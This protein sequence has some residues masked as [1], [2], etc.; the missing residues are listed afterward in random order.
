MMI[1]LSFGQQRLWFVDQ[2]DSLGGLYTIPLI[3][4][5]TGSLDPVSLANA[6][7]DVVAR[8]E[9]LRTIFPSPNGNPVQQ[10]LPPNEAVVEL[11]V[12][13]VTEVDLTGAVAEAKAQPFDLATEIPIRAELFALAATEH[14]LAVTIHHIAADGWSMGLL[15]RDLFTAYNARTNGHPPAFPDL[16][17]QY[18]DY[19]LWQRELLGSDDDPHSRLNQQLAYWRRALAH[20]PEEL[21]LPTDRPRPRVASHHGAT[22]EVTIPADVHQQLHALARAHE[23]TVFMTLQAALAVLLARLG[24][25]EDIPI[26]APIAGRTDE[27]FDDLIGFFVNTLVLR[28]DLSGNPTYSQTLARV[29]ETTIDAYDHQDL[30]FER[31]VE[32]LA[33]TRSMAR[34]PLFQVALTLNNTPA[35]ALHLPGLESTALP[36]GSMPA[37]FDLEFELAE[38]RNQN[39]PSGIHGTLTY[40]TDLFD[41][42]TAQALTQRLIFTLRT[43]TTHPDTPL[44]RLEM[45][46]EVERRRVLGE[47]NDTA[48]EVP[49]VTLPGLFEE[50]VGRIPGSTAVVFGERCVSYGE[51]NGRANRLARL[52]VARGVGAEDRV[53][54]VMGRGAELVVALLGVLKA[55]AA[56]VPIDPAYPAERIGFMLA[57]AQPAVVL[58]TRE[59]TPAVPE[60]FAGPLL[61]LDDP[62]TAAFLARQDSA[63]LADTERVRPLLPEHP[64]YVIFTSGSTGRPKGVVIPHAA[65]ANFLTDMSRRFPLGTEDCWAAVTTIAFD[66]AALELYLPLISGARLELVPRQTVIDIPALAELLHR[67][68]TTIMQATPS[69]WHALTEHLTQSTMELPRLRIL[70]GGE[71]LPEPLATTLGSLAD[72]TNLYGPTET[73]IWSTTAPI[74]P[75]RTPTIGRPIANT[76]TYVLDAGLQPV[77]TG[78][79]GELYIAG[80]GLARGYLNQPGLT[81][82]RFVACPFASGERMYRTGDVVRWNNRGELVFLGRADDQV[83]I[84]GFRIELGE[85]EAALLTYEDI[86]QAAVIVREDVLGD[87]RLA[88]YVVPVHGASGNRKPPATDG[89]PAVDGSSA[90]GGS[91]DSHGLS[92]QSVRRFIAARLPHFMVPSAVVALDE[93][94]LTVNGK[95]DRKALPVPDYLA[96]SCGVGGRGPRTAREEVLCAA[97]VEVLGVPAVGI[98]DN[99][100]ELGGHSLLAVTLVARLREQGVAVS[101]R[102]MFDTPTVAALAEAG[103][104]DVVVVPPNLIP[105]GVEVITPEML[106]LVD[107]TAAEIELIASLVPGGAAN[108]ADIYPLA[109]LQEGIFFHHLMGTGGAGGDVYARP[110]VLGFDTRERVD[111]FVEALRRVVERHDVLRTGVQW[112][113]LSQPV[114]VVWRSA[115]LPVREIVLDPE[116]GDPVRQLLDAGDTAIDLAQAPLMRVT[117]APNPDRPGSGTGRCP[118]FGAGAG[119]GADGAVESAGAEW[120]L[121]LC[122]HH[123]VQDHTAVEVMLG[124]V[125]AFLTGGGEGL[126]VPVPFRDFVAQARLGAPPWEHVRYFADLLGDVEEPSAPFGVLDVLGDGSGTAEAQLVVDGEL[127]ARVRG[128]ARE[129]GVSAATVM[130]AAWAR[131]VAA[132]SGCDDVVFGTVLFGRMNAGTGAERALGLFINTLPVRL[133]TTEHNVATAL[134]VMQTQLAALLVREHAPLA[135]AQHAS[136]LTP[137]TPL[138]TTIL[139]YRHNPQDRETTLEGI[140]FLHSEG[141]TNYPLTASIDD[142]GTGFALTVEAVAPIDPHAVCAMFHT[143]IN[144]FVTAL[145]SEPHTLLSRVGVLEEAE[146][147]LLLVGWNDTGRDVPD[148]TLPELFEV[149]VCRT[150]DSTAVAFEGRCLSYAE[151][152][153]RANQLARLLTGQGVGAEDRVAVMMERSVDLV[154]AL[155]AVLKTGAA[156]LPID[157]AYPGERITYILADAKPAIVLTTREAAPAVPEESDIPLLVPDDPPTA[158]VLEGEDT[159]DMTDAERV[160]PLLPE[161]PAYV[162]YT[163][164]STGRPKGV[165]VAQRGVVNRLAW[166]QS[167]Y[168]LELGDR[169]LQKT[170]FGFDVSVWEFF[171]PL[172]EGATLVVARPGGHQDPAYL[173]QLIQREHITLLHFVPS[174]LQ[175]FLR[176]PAAANCTGLRAVLCSGE[177]LPADLCDRFH[178]VLDVP[179]HNLY[180]PTEASIDVTAWPCTPGTAGPS[181]PIGRPV[182]NTRVFV[183]DAALQPVPVGVPAE[184]YLAG[185][186]LARGYLNQPALTAERFI[187]CPFGTGERMYRTGDIVRWN[188]DGTLVYLGRT[189]DQVKIRGFR[190]ELGEIEAALLSHDTI[191]QAAVTVR[192]DSPGGK[193]LVAYVVPSGDSGLYE[194]SVVLGTLRRSLATRLPEYMVPSAVVVLEELPLTVNG[195][196]DRKALPA[197]DYGGSSERGP[198]TPREE[199]LCAAFAE[200]LGLPRVGIDDNFF[201]LGGH[202]L[203]SVRLASRVQAALG[204]ELTLRTLFEAPTVARLAE[205]LDSDSRDGSSMGLW[206]VLLPLRAQGSGRPLFC[207]HPGEGMSWLYA[208]LM[209][210]LGAGVPIY[211]LQA[212]GLARPEAL[213]RS[214]EEMAADYLHEIRTVQPHGPYRLLGWSFGGLVAHTIATRLQAQGEQVDLLAILDAYPPTSAEGTAVDNAEDLERK[215]LAGLLEDLGYD[216]VKVGGGQLSRPTVAQFLQRQDVGLALIEER[217]LDAILAVSLNNARLPH[218]FTPGGYRGDVL[219]FNAALDT[220]VMASRTPSEWGPYVEGWIDSH[221]IPCAHTAMFEDGPVALIGRILA[222]ELDD[223]ARNRPQSQEGAE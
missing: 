56:Y 33:P 101:V 48:C 64:A 217:H 115:P 216:A 36:T 51:V 150:P 117:I 29:R 219:F 140:R 23:V 139:N 157:P 84:R 118:D 186:Q 43:L 179:L 187:A 54:V 119:L 184:L 171:W 27:A 181:V 99:F 209:R 167:A 156:Y 98:D 80:S 222:H 205:W 114:Q 218:C 110:A 57:D 213:A 131:V 120:L 204:V 161:H 34:H 88:A 134:R 8:H 195:K 77:P 105:P 199:I 2:L 10:V 52:L 212:R 60:P 168:P 65:L 152:N 151:V 4:R 91:S 68:G 58:T 45:L 133:T 19:T 85:V 183:L 124:E 223:L 197:P 21:T 13:H 90:K 41:H 155:L 92:A 164:G 6:L 141:H 129:R 93:L 135:L 14:V 69:L 149:Q 160:R 89:T 111:T 79:T 37:K 189:D 116:G 96:A 35:T 192:E 208:R 28:T 176:E 75:T 221:D 178:A 169:V 55:G 173:V 38:S 1:P 200:V 112:E 113:G 82:G 177:A 62:S 128:A 153:A 136:A 158:A 194:R 40:A 61:V 203:L 9:A 104:Q 67:C 11:P 174:M 210:E 201:E 18:A 70:T 46:T 20:L 182:A 125:G 144:N 66:I 122:T 100:F 220:G 185:T 180:G 147:R 146:S 3:V 72:V 32:D 198:R 148:A 87:K 126:P 107:L 24:A 188:N 47:W 108:V 159:A 31:L 30:P 81:A 123:L 163:S 49:D 132:T 7:R 143:A 130:H 175:T 78:V 5:L 53:G 166:A 196:L 215:V 103:A 211:G 22:V 71:A 94:P 83:K 44:C 206:E 142:T 63:D 59:A 193:R 127:A 170:P 42:E 74:T 39:Q 145:E 106:P 109:P 165:A 207:I 137:P 202:S 138:F 16:P 154:V 95:L 12:T 76:R 97:F 172:L 25:G 86:A 73:T 214:V 50:Q 15:A 162:I 191:A 190:I 121:L 17:V 102:A 26:G